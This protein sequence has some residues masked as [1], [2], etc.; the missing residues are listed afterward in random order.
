MGNGGRNGG[1]PMNGSPLRRLAFSRPR[2]RP[3]RRGV[4]AVIRDAG[5]RYLL[6]KRAESLKRSP[7]WWCFPGGAVEAGETPAQA[8][9]RELRE[10]LDLAVR[11]RGLVRSTISPGGEFLVLWLRATCR[12]ANPRLRPNP[13]EVAEVRFLSPAAALPLGPLLP[14]LRAWLRLQAGYTSTARGCRR[15]GA[16]RFFAAV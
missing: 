10:E 11:C 13:A 5:G 15:S 3:R 16:S 6:I 1:A 9:E 14:T 7:G 12:E 8:L 2:L 4:A